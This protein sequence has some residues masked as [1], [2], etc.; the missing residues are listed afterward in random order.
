MEK[1]WG[2]VSLAMREHV[3]ME[4]VF[5]VWSVPRLYNQNH[6]PLQE[7]PE[8]VDR[9]VGGCC[10]MAASLQG[11]EPGSRGTSTF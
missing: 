8:T 3:I 6:L 1:F 5:S 10:E 9:R 7:G 2:H 11:R 4:E